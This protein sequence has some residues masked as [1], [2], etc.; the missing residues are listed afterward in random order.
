MPWGISIQAIHSHPE[1]EILK[2][3]SNFDELN[4]S[5]SEMNDDK[6]SSNLI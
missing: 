6:N 1:Q 3:S 5:E 4:I 2:E